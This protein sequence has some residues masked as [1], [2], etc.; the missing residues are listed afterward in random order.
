MF[1]VCSIRTFPDRTMIRAN[2]PGYAKSKIDAESDAE[3]LN[4]QA[5]DGVVFYVFLIR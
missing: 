3:F 5:A 4:F 1:G 2:L